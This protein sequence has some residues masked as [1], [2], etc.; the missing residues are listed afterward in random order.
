[1][2]IKYTRSYYL[3]FLYNTVKLCYNDIGFYD[4][5]KVQTKFKSVSDLGLVILI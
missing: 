2:C 5:G 1:M 4:T 3:F